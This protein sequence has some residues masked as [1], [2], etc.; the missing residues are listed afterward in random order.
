MPEMPVESLSRL[1]KLGLPPDFM[2]DALLD[3]FATRRAISPLHPRGF[4][5]MAGWA[6]VVAGLRRRLIPLGWIPEDTAE[7]LAVITSPDGQVSIAVSSGDE[8][9]GRADMTPRS[10]YR[11]GWATFRA[12]AQ[13][14]QMEMFGVLPMVPRAGAS[15]SGRRTYFLLFA[16]VAG[17]IRSELS[18]PQSIGSDDRLSGWSE[19]VLLS[20]IATADE[21]SLESQAK[22]EFVVEVT[23]K[24]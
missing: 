13:N 22:E 7:G 3:G 16:E 6:E 20:P 1:A 4:R 2:R 21:A 9:T 23:R 14:E 11:K 17:E 18:L 10:R 24:R 19:R 8:N 12:V 5:G 15:Q